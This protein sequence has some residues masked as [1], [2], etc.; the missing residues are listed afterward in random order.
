[1]PQPKYHGRKCHHHGHLSTLAICSFAIGS[2]AYDA[3]ICGAN[4]WSASDNATLYYDSDAWNPVGDGFQCMSINSNPPS[5]DATWSWTEESSSVHSFPH[6]QFQSDEMPVALD[7]IAS[8]GLNVQWSYS[9]G[10][11]ATSSQ[12]LLALS[13]SEETVLA[14]VAFDMF[15]AADPDS[16]LTSKTA[17]AEIMIWIGTVGTPWPIGYSTNRS[18]YTQKLGG[19]TFTLYIGQNSNNATVY[20]W[21]T[22]TNQTGFFEDVSPLLQYLWRNNLVDADAYLGLVQ[23]GTEAYHAA[24]NVTLSASN[25]SMAL[26]IGTPPHLD[27]SAMPDS[28]SRATAVDVPSANRLLYVLVTATCLVL[29]GS[30]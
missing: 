18:C 17:S 11:D 16:A 29:L 19:V 13:L 20:T 30:F 10:N 14:N 2:L 15:L 7:R 27:I 24:S 1:M 22:A 25:F 23:Y 3:V 12:R 21:H 6:V 4:G 28:C 9:T 5:F 8:L 26:E